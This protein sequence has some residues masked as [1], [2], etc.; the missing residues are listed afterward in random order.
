MMMLQKLG[1][2][3]MMLLLR[4]V[5]MV[6]LVVLGLAEVKLIPLLHYRYHHRFAR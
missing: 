1:T 3:V 6:V 4:V 5:V 2:V